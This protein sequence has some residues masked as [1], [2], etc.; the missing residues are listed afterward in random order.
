MAGAPTKSDS[1]VITNPLYG[2]RVTSV[3]DDTL[4]VRFWV[5]LTLIAQPRICAVDRAGGQR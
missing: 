2:K 1:I 3:G 5:S 4:Q